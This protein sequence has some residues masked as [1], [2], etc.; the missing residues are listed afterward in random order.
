MNTPLNSALAGHETGKSPPRKMTD[1]PLIAGFVAIDKSCSVE[2]NQPP[3]PDVTCADAALFGDSPDQRHTVAKVFAIVGSLAVAVV[4]LIYLSYRILTFY[5]S[6][7]QIHMALEVGYVIGMLALAVAFGFFAVRSLGRYSR[8]RKVERF[9]ALAAQAR[10]GSIGH[11]QEKSL[12]TMIFRFVGF[13]R[14]H[15]DTDGAE[16]C[17]AANRLQ[18]RLNTHADAR[19]S[20]DELE[21]YL[22]HKI[23]QRADAFIRRRAAQVVVGTALAYGVLDFLVVAWQAMAMIDGISRL[24]SGRPGVFGTLRLLRRAMVMG[25]V[26]DVAEQA[27]ELLTDAVAGKLAVKLG[28]RVA[29]GLGN[30]Y[31]MLRFGDAVKRQCRPISLPPER[32]LT[33]DMITETYALITGKP[34]T[35]R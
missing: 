3:P 9:Q 31:L 13:V 2:E 18:V 11:E 28:A 5:E 19:R 14:E 30:G 32:L 6:C 24:Y 23:D 8:L 33:T 21:E 17:K 26:A 16:T 29:Q 27:A 22:L 25:V 1:D 7:C 15:G 10:R 12:R 4:A 20:V 35:P 34:V